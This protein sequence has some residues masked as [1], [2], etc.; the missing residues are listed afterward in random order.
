MSTEPIRVAFVLN[1]FTAGGAQELVAAL[2]R[3]LDPNRF[4]V[5]VISLRELPERKDF[6][7]KLP[8]A[9][10]AYRL[11]F[12][13]FVDISAWIAYIRLLRRER[14]RL[15]ISGL[16][17]ANA[18][19][20]IAGFLVGVPTVATEHNTYDAKSFWMR[21]VDALLARFSPCVIAVSKGVADFTAR[22]EGISPKKFVVIP[23]GVAVADIQRA[24]AV[25][26]RKALRQ[27]FNLTPDAIVFLCVGR[28]TAQK[29]Q[30]ALL[31]AFASVSAEPGRERWKL[32]VAGQGTLF[33]EFS[34]YIEAHDLGGRVRLLGHYEPMTDLYAISDVLV[35]V[36]LIEGYGIARA[37]ARAVGLPILTTPVAGTEEL[38]TDGLH[39]FVCDGYDVEH[40]RNALCAITPERLA[41]V[42][43]SSAAHAQEVDIS[44]TIA[45][46]E[47]LIARMVGKDTI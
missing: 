29:N 24:V 34:A 35:S 13:S 42:R 20:R 11:S 23:N 14:F 16:F 15:V 12:K 47:K 44:R 1:D 19:A 43:K 38:V 41:A 25:A 5:S 28:L 6:F 10:P 17:F 4:A 40:I 30:R 46:Y 36:S 8:A 22:T 31:E 32:L 9:I 7:H 2:A 33:D 37:E 21:R 18:V 39:G 45:A 27:K 26:D 3:G